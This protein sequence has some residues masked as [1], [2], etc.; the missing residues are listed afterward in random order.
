MIFMAFWLPVIMA[1]VTFSLPSD[2]WR[3][4]LLPLGALGHL[5]V[6][7]RAIFWSDSVSPASA[8]GGWL[9]LDALGK[10]FLGFLSLFFFLCSLYVPGYLSASARAA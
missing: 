3:P 2:R 4:W 7:F 1:A 9:L 10:L 5:L 8:L 6:V